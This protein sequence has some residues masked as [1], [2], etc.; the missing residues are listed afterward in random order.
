MPPWY[1]RS[2]CWG[3]AERCT[4]PSRI[5]VVEQVRQALAEDLGNGDL[6]AA[7]VP[8][9]AAAR[10]RVIVREPAIL[11]GLDWFNEVFHQLDPAIELKWFGQG[12]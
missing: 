2:S 12:W 7:L 8:A 5:D 4:G 9:D 1:L 6:T 3:S 11:C 10:A